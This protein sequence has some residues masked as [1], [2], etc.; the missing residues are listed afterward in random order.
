[1]IEKHI[2]AR[3]GREAWAAIESLKITG[4]FTSFSKDRAVHVATQARPEMPF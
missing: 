2:A 1:M 3:G 4:D